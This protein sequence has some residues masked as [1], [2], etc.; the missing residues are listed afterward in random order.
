MARGASGPS[1]EQV[2][3]DVRRAADGALRPVYWV[4]GPE[5]LRA[6]VVNEAIKER[7][8]RG[9]PAGLNYDV[10]A[11]GSI[12]GGRIADLCRELPMMAPSRLVLVHDADKLNES[13]ADAIIAYLER[14]A[15]ETVLLLNA[16]TADVRTRLVKKVMEAG[17]LVRCDE[18]SARE[19]PGWIGREAKRLG[20]TLAAEV[21]DVLAETVGAELGPLRGALEKLSL[22]VAPRT[23]VELA[24]VEE[25]ITHTKAHDAFELAAAILARDVVEAMRVLE[26]ILTAARSGEEVPLLGMVAWQM[27]QLLRGRDLLAAGRHP[28]EI[29]ETLRVFGEK[30]SMFL[31]QVRAARGKD[32]LRAHRALW[33]ADRAMKGMGAGVLIPGMMGPK[34]SPRSALEAVV[35]KLCARGGEAVA[36]RRP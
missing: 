10:A 2:A 35:V 24:D 22:Y 21:P 32:L 4:Y 14:P 16:R 23:D 3:Q 34:R 28:D 36:A 9:S 29:A 7:A 20:L 11:A 8:L 1:P 27:R 26:R 17:A 12:S 33:E 30:K 18:L 19:I 31:R 25:A 6:D 5:V 13:D 15:P